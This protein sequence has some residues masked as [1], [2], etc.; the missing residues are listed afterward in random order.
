VFDTG[1]SVKIKRWRISPPSK[2][3][4]SEESGDAARKETKKCLQ[5]YFT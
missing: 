5:G 3:Y 4:N 2:C 1:F